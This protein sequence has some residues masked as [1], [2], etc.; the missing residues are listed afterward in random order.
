MFITYVRNQ[1]LISRSNANRVVMQ[2]Q[3]KARIKAKKNSIT[4]LGGIEWRLAQFT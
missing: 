3:I 1:D 2:F 4:S